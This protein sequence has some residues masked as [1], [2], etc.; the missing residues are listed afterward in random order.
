MLAATRGNRA[1]IQSL[2]FLFGTDGSAGSH[3]GA[4][5]SGSTFA[6]SLG[7]TFAGRDNSWEAPPFAGGG[8]AEGDGWAD[9][10]GRGGGTAGGSK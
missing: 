6:P 4:R 3:G 10:Q 7:F 1:D 5:V 2:P 9:G 8:W